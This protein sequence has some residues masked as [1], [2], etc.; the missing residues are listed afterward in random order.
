M[1]K[2]TSTTLDEIYCK[3]I[4]RDINLI[5]LLYTKFNLKTGLI[6]KYPIIKKGSSDN[7]R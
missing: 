1:I 4:E 3:F 6:P 7:E 5:W 2:I